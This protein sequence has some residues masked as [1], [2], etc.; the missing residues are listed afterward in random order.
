MRAEFLILE[1]TANQCTAESQINGIPICRLTPSS[2][3]D[4][5]PV[6]EYLIPG[7][8]T[9]TLVVEP[10]PTPS[11]ALAPAAQPF[12][13]KDKTRASLRL[14]GMPPGS[15]PEDPGVRELLR[16]NWEPGAGQAVAV[17]AVIEKAIEIPFAVRHWSWLA[18]DSFENP[19]SL[20]AIAAM[21]AGLRESFERRD[22][23]PFIAR[24]QVRFRELSAAY[25]LDLATEVREFREQFERLSVEGGF[26]WQPLDVEQID[27]RLCAG[28]R[29]VDCVD[30]S[31]EPLLRSAKLPNGITRVRYPI[32]VAS[33]G[34]S[35]QIVR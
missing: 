31:W 23:E 34:G 16:L 35:L 10:G 28:A 33:L 13:L 32:R 2:G 1:T 14:M 6:H 27:L 15:F 21:I 26:E 24:A 29:L 4:S 22:P 5:T 9:F 20:Q 17:P 7:D 12:V 3:L 18:G 19:A 8:N 25:E 30:R 11:Q